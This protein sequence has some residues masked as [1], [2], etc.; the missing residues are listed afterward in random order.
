MAWTISE[1]KFR[2]I[3]GEEMSIHMAFFTCYSK[4]VLPNF[5]GI[6]ISRSSIFLAFPSTNP[7]T[8]E[9]I[10]KFA[11]TNFPRGLSW[12]N[13]KFPASVVINSLSRPQKQCCTRHIKELLKGNV[14]QRGVTFLK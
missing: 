9:I 1:R 14:T 2:K 7:R 12:A 8:S 11:T 5:R 13:F 3:R 6:P 10:C 4:M